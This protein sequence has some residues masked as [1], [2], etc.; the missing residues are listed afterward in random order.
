VNAGHPA[1]LVVARNGTI[2]RLEEGGLLLGVDPA[3]AYQVGA[4]S[5]EP[6]EVLLL[7]SDGVT[8]VLNGEDEDYGTK[9]LETLLPRL[10]HLPGAAILENVIASV[11]AFV[12]GSLPDDITLLVAKFVP[13][14]PRP[15]PV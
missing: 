11:E 3:A 7:Y 14:A 8:D 9:R 10:A 13:P 15:R 12:G 1:G 6:G 4:E 2:R 5:F